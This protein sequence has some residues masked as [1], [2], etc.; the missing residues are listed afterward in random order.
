MVA[1]DRLGKTSWA[2]TARLGS[3][4]LFYERII[5]MGG[6]HEDFQNVLHGIS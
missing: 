4:G 3:I 1:M 5:F 2:A 6:D